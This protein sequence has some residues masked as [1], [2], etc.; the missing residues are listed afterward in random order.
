[1][2]FLQLAQKR[3]SVRKFSKKPIE[4]DQLIKILE[5]ARWAPSACNNQP[6]IFVVLKDDNSKAKLKSVYNRD[7]FLT[8]PVIVA[9]CCDR[10]KSWKRTDGKEFGD[11]DVALAMDHLTLAAA[12]ASIGTCW[13]GAFEFNEAKRV[14]ALP[15][16]IDPVAFT[17]LGYPQDPVT[18]KR[19]K[20]L[21]DIIYWESFNG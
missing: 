5:A 10:T 6:W 8:A 20:D 13:I 4:Q 19:R 3:C 17:P 15:A 16:H 18:E 7:W 14:L 12:E 21:Q 11:I 9:A 1:M 2:E